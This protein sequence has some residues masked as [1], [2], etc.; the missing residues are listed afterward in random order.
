M[1]NMSFQNNNSL[2]APPG[3]SPPPKSSSMPIV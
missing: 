3:L 2:T 1:Q